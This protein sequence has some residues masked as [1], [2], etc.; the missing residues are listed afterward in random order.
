MAVVVDVRA[1]PPV[2]GD[3]VVQVPGRRVAL[4]AHRAFDVPG[5]ALGTPAQHQPGPLLPA[6]GPGRLKA[7]SLSLTAAACW[8]PALRVGEWGHVVGVLCAL[9]AGL[10]VA[11][12]AGSVRRWTALPTVRGRQPWLPSSDGR[13]RL[14]GV[15]GVSVAA[16]RW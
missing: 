5:P 14:R 2:A 7:V 15:A 9:G 3:D 8:L 4:L 10:A 16:G 6:V 13:P 11:T 12:A 1:K